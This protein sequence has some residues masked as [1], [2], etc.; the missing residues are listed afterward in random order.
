MR[1]TRGKK[2]AVLGTMF[3]ASGSLVA[4]TMMGASGAAP[5]AQQAEPSDVTRAK[6]EPLNN[7]GVKGNADV[8]VNGRRVTVDL[9]A[10]RLLKKSP[11]AQHI[12]FGAKARNECPT[13][14]DDDNAD[15]RLNTVEGQPAYG[16][17]RVSLTTKGDTTA[18]STLAVNRFPTAPKG[19]VNY[20]RRGIEVSKRVARGIRNGNAVVVVHGLDYNGN[21]KYD[22]AAGKSEL[23]PALPA[24]ATDPASCGVLEPVQP[25]EEEPPLP[26]PRSGR[27]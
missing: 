6:L 3:L 9:N 2:Q 18:K 27:N 1:L 7:S 17:V 25:T 24:E 21:G 20:D 26:L 15:H 10:R 13:V 19:E 5:A 16:P 12:H 23:D 11:H 22:F 14:R 8:V 4:T